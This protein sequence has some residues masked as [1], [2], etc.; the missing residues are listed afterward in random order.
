MGFLK[1][2]KVEPKQVVQSPAIQKPPV[3]SKKEVSL[4]SKEIKIKGEI[5]GNDD[6]IIE[7]NVE[8]KIEIKAHL[9]V[10]TSGVVKAELF[11]KKITISGKVYGNIFAEENVEIQPSGFL[12]GNITSPKI[13]IQEGA[14][15][16]GSVDMKSHQKEQKT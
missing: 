14:H 10:Q 9:T 5:Q 2:D 13:T 16:K 4:I 6:L 8:G 15:F 3:P 1:K 7:G 11:A 12:E